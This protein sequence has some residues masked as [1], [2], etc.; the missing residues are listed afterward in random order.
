FSF[1]MQHNLS[2]TIT[3]SFSYTLIWSSPGDVDQ[4]PLPPDDSVVLDGDYDPFFIHALG[5]TFSG[6]F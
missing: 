5:F 3:A 1:G 6:R 4:V 2:D